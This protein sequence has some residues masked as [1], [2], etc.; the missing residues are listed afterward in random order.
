MSLDPCINPPSGSQLASACA[1]QRA[2]EALSA[3]V[4]AYNIAV[5]D[6]ATRHAEWENQMTN[7]NDNLIPLWNQRSNNKLNSLTNEVLKTGCGTKCPS[8]YYEIDYWYCSSS[9]TYKRD[10]KR[11]S[12][13]IQTDWNAWV[14]A[15][16][17]PVAPP[18]PTLGVPAPNGSNILCCSQEFSGITADD[19]EFDNIVQQCQ[20]NIT[21]QIVA[22]AVQDTAGNSA[23]VIGSITTPPP[24]TP[25]TTPQPPKSTTAA[26]SSIIAMIILLLI[27]IPLFIWLARKK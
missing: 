16:P 14:Q 12:D 7:Y 4:E 27:L 10:C 25:I 8:G 15:N 26:R 18:E 3:Q 23:N 11:T 9:L 24:T 13:Q 20:Q 17:A 5:E 22:A 2:A 21:N 1:C 6:F 19:V